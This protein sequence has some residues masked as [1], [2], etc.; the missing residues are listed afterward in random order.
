M[1]YKIENERENPFFKRKD[2]EIS[3]RHLGN[4]TPSK[5]EIVKELAVKYKVDETQVQVKYVSVKKGLGESIAILKILK[6][7]PKVEVKEEP[8]SEE[9]EAPANTTE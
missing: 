6:E 9:N 3:I 8:K 5:L 4:A 1:D 2:V 7:K